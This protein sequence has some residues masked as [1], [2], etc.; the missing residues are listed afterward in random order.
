[1]R[2]FSF[3]TAALKSDFLLQAHTNRSRGN[4]KRTSI[5]IVKTLCKVKKAGMV[6]TAKVSGR[7]KLEKKAN[8]AM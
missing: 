2:M 8:G 4:K 6:A 1:M 3:D 7:S 5:D